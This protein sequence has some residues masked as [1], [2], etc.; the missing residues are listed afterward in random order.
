M[1]LKS[2]GIGLIGLFVLAF[3]AWAGTPALEGVVKDPAGRPIKGADVRIEA[4]NFSKIVKTDASGHYI[5]DGLAA[6]TYKVTLVVN[7][8]VKA[9]IMNAKTQL[10]KPTQLNFDLTAKMAP[11]KKHTHM[12]Y[13]APDTGTLIGGGRWVEVDDHG[14]P[15]NST[16]SNVD[17]MSG[18]AVSNIIPSTAGRSSTIVTH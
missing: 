15:V 11:V 8:S 14:N 6:A 1:F 9:S 4:K 3:S 5:S 17:K 2:L 12:V 16:T 18:S 10:G 13:V 7:G